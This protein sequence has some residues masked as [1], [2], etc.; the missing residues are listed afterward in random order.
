MLLLGN[1]SWNVHVDHVVGKAA[2]ELNYIQRN[3]ISANA[4]LRNIVH[5]TGIRIILEC[6]CTLWGPSQVCLVDKLKKKFKT[7]QPDSS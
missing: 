7:E 3:L 2:V 6:A 4:N 5:L 1:C